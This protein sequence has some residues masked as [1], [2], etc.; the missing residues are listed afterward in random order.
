MPSY[1]G[2]YIQVIKR[3]IDALILVMVTTE[4]KTEK[5]RKKKKLRANSKCKY[6][7]PKYF[8]FDNG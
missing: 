7:C 2:Y 6:S 1:F 3:N 8:H 4:I 5:K